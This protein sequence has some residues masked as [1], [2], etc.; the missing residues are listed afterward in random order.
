MAEI[1][2][3]ARVADDTPCGRGRSGQIDMRSLK[4]PNVA[5]NLATAVSNN[6]AAYIE[7]HAAILETM[8]GETGAI[9]MMV[10]F[11]RLAMSKGH[12]GNS[13]AIP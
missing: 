12:T 2:L 11:R 7:N 13:A 8:S 3:R 4:A 10:K 9:S 5:N 6:L 1:G